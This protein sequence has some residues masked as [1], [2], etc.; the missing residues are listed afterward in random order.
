MQT[1][2]PVDDLEAGTLKPQLG[3]HASSDHSKVQPDGTAESF[4]ELDSASLAFEAS[5]RLGFLR[6]VFGILSLQLAL[7]CAT[8]GYFMYNKAARSF[9]LASPSL[10]TAS[11]VLG[12]VL[13]FA[14]FAYKDRHPLN[15]QLLGAWTLCQAIMVGTV[16]ARFA[17]AGMGAVVLQA[18][19]LT[20]LVFVSLTMY[21][22]QSKRDFSFM[23][24]ALWSGLL[25]MMGWGVV[26]WLFGFQHSSLYSL[27]GA[28]LFS[29]FIIYD[30]HMVMKKI[31][32]DDYILA[33]INL[34]LDIINL[35]LYIL[36]ILASG[37]RR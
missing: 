9:V 5:V 23:G 34:Y 18:A 2:Q 24:G 8:A 29:M 26:Q 27:C 22:L 15:L 4:G 37:D 21:T 11:I 32:V 6:K 19:V 35:F 36:D 13:L 30:V 7:T 12:L 1:Y 17:Q 33:V 31:G 14:L 25:I 20:M 3:G 16:C 10:M 28:L